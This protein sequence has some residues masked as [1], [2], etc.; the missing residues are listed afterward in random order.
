MGIRLVCFIAA[1]LV[2]GGWVTWVLIGAA[3]VLPYTAVLFANAGK[4]QA[5]YDSSPM[6]YLALPSRGTERLAGPEGDKPTDGDVKG[7]QE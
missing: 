7:T 6:E 3:I 5:H 2:G 4:D 1:I